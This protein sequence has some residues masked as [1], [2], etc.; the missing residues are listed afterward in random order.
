MSK[1]ENVPF[2]EMY[3]GQT[4]SYEKTVSEEDILMFA[5]LSGD[6]NP[7][8]LDEA[9][10]STTQFGE[11]IAHGM[12]TAALISAAMAMQ[13]PG[14]GSIYLTQ[15]M[16]FKAPVKIGDALTVQIE[17]TSKRE[18][19][20]IAT[21]STVVYNQHGKKVVMGEAMARV[22]SE[23]IILDAPELPEIQIG[24]AGPR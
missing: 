10:A 8:H 20:N 12:Y 24:E 14:P 18:N 23:K 15:T 19:R 22:P 11:R 17:V 21:L 4:C 16:K 9:Y 2:D 13:I 5:K 7:V 6:T 3:V 1:I